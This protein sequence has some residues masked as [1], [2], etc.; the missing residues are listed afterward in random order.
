MAEMTLADHAEAWQREQGREVPVRGTD[1]WQAMYE[2]WATWAF[3]DLRSEEKRHSDGQ[4]GG[5]TLA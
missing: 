1:D 4:A 3:A 2:A 5:T